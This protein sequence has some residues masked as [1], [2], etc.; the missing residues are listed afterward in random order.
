V[1]VVLEEVVLVT[2]LYLAQSP[3]MVAVQED[4]TRPVLAELVALVVA[5][6]Q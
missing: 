4:H 1:L 2:I 5:A 6:E 3:Q